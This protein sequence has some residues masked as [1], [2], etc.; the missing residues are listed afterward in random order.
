MTNET[1]EIIRAMVDVLELGPA[2]DGYDDLA[3]AMLR[4]ALETA[5]YDPT[6][7]PLDP[8]RV[9]MMHKLYRAAYGETDG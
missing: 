2:R 3:K 5:G 1:N 6:H 8:D 4:A 9:N 7:W